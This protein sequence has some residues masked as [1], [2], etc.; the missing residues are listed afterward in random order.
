MKTIRGDL[1]KLALAGH[2]DVIVHGCNCQCRMSRGIALAIKNTFPEAVAADLDT[3]K[4]DPAKLGTYSSAT[5][6]RNGRSVTIVNAYTQLHPEGEGVLVD[7]DA[8]RTVMRRISVGFAGNRIG[9]PKIGAG[10]ARGDWSVISL[11]IQEELAGEDHTL[12]EFEP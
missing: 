1:V 2:F 3:L 10:L 4:G 9:Y 12:V 6:E 8:V 7:Y 11:V 5:V